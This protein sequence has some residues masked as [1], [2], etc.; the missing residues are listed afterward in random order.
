[1]GGDLFSGNIGSGAD[2]KKEQ[3]TEVKGGGKCSPPGPIVVGNGNAEPR[4]LR[5]Q[6]SIV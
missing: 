5:E 3:N 2:D 4:P 1:L 6:D